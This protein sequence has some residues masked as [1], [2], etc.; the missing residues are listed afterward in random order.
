LSFVFFFVGEKRESEKR[1]AEELNKIN[2]E[3]RKE[4]RRTSQ[5]EG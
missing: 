2:D 4:E 5:Q 3:K 1:L